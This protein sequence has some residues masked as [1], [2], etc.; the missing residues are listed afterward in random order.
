[1]KYVSEPRQA[2]FGPETARLKIFVLARA[3]LSA[4]TQGP[5]IIKGY[6]ASFLEPPGAR[7]EMDETGNVA[8]I[9]YTQKMVLGTLVFCSH[10]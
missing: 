5:A 7:A 10:G 1:M 6:D 3:D 4:P 8:I 9:L 2:Y